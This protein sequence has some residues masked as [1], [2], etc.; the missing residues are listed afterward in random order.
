M[1]KT[2]LGKAISNTVFNSLLSTFPTNFAQKFSLNEQEVKDF[3][4]EFLSGADS[5]KPKRTTGPNGYVLFSS[6]NRKTIQSELET[7]GKLKDLT[8]KEAFGLVGKEVGARWSLLPADEKANWNSKAK[9]PKVAPAAE[10]AKPEKA[11]PATDKVKKNIVKKKNNATETGLK[12]DVDSST[13]VKTNVKKTVT[14]DTS[15]VV[16]TVKKVRKARAKESDDEAS[17]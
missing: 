16:A 13:P 6:S 11:A 7:S 5:T 15:P 12:P 1:H 9:N 2:K 10:P 4:T 3:L 17:K 14:S 8:K